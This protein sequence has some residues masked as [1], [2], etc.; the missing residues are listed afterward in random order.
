MLS[1][2]VTDF[3]C[4]F[5]AFSRKAVKKV[6]SKAQINGWGYDA[7]ILFLAKNQNLSL[8]EVAVTWANDERTKVNLKSAIIKTLVELATIRWIHSVKPALRFRTPRFQATFRFPVIKRRLSP[9][10]I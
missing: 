1:T 3:T 2:N 7:E 8:R 4:G 9:V 5:K 6:F 10:K